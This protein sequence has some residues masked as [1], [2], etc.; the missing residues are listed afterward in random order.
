MGT[1]GDKISAAIAAQI[2]AE[3][4][5]RGWS[6]P[7]LAKRAGFSTSSVYRYLDGEREMKL[8]DIAD[9]ARA[10]EMDAFDLINRAHRRL[11]GSEYIQ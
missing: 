6:K 7:E 9:F 5:A 1:N 8:G 11:D 10:F 3:M 2:G 4:G